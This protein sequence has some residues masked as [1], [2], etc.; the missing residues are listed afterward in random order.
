MLMGGAP[1]H[2]SAPM[3]IS[4]PSPAGMTCLVSGIYLAKYLSQ[5][6]SGTEAEGTQRK[7]RV[8]G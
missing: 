5:T 4:V 7:E 8:N 6:T 2:S 1:P 3:D